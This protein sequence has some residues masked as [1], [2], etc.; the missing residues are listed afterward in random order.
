MRARKKKSIN[1]HQ[2]TQTLA[3]LEWEK[4]L[5]KVVNRPTDYKWKIL[6]KSIKRHTNNTRRTHTHSHLQ[7]LIPSRSIHLANNF[8]T[9]FS[10]GLLIVEQ[11][12][13]RSQVHSP[14]RSLLF[15]QNRFH[16]NCISCNFPHCF[17]CPLPAF[18]PSFALYSHYCMPSIMLRRATM[19]LTHS[20]KNRWCSNEGN[21]WQNFCRRRKK[22]YMCSYWFFTE[23]SLLSWKK[24]RVTTNNSPFQRR[25]KN[26]SLRLPGKINAQD[27]L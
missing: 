1:S 20:T 17:F 26:R 4:S 15:F 25:T 14:A 8:Q 16:L 12:I 6:E 9:N 10:R 7:M 19:F 18:T 11:A 5:P 21:C 2:C 24:F 27:I 3:L 22:K 13:E 23:E